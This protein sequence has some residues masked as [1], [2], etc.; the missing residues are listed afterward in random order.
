[1]RTLQEV[2]SLYLNAKEGTEVGQSLNYDDRL[3]TVEFFWRDRILEGE[4]HIKQGQLLRDQI[5]S[6]HSPGSQ[7]GVSSG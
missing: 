4:E 2:V 5:F 6:I 7:I 1:M 3:G